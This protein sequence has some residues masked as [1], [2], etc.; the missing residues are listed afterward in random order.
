[1]CRPAA[2]ERCLEPSINERRITCVVH[3]TPGE[4]RFVIRD[5]GRGFSTQF[6]SAGTQDCFEQG[7]H[8]GLTLIHS[9]MD[10]VSSNSKGNEL[11][12]RKL[13]R[14]SAE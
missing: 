13:A 8:R 1:M 10:Q 9:L 2:R 4:A 5:E 3:I 6:V 12:M 11:T 14:M 7:S